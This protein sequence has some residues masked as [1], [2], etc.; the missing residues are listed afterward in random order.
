MVDAV[1]ASPFGIVV[2]AAAVVAVFAALGRCAVPRLERVP[3]RA[4]GWRDLLGNA[5]VGVH[6]LAG[7]GDARGAGLDGAGH[8]RHA[9][10]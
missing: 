9:G 6:V 10:P 1:L 8:V 4:W 2:Y 7:L 3:L 5:V